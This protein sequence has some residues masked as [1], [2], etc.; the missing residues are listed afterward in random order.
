MEGVE[1]D[2]ER[3]RGDGSKG[4]DQVRTGHWHNDRMWV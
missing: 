2:Y 3:H 1:R 4:G